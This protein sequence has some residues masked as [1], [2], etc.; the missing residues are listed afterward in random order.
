VDQRSS[1][2]FG[3]FILNRER[4]RLEDR[5]GA[6][7]FLR[8][9]SYR[10]LEVL[11]ERHGQLVSKD[12]LVCE[13]WPDLF[14]S[15]DS[16]A[17]C[18][19]DIRRALG[20]EG[21]NLLRTVPKRGYMLGA[22]AAP[23]EALAPRRAKLPP[24][25]AGLT[26]ALAVSAIWWGMAR[27]PLQAVPDTT[28][29]SVRQANALLET[30]DWRRR[31]D[32][33]RAR[34]LLESAAAEDP[35]NADTLASLGLTYWLGVQHIA[36]GGGRREMRRALELVE[37]AVA[38]GG[39]ARSHRLLAEMRL[40]SPFADM[41]SPVDALAS[42]RA[43]VAIDDDDA[44]NLA[45]LAQA[46]A[47]TGRAKEAVG[48][49]EHALRLE[50]S[51]PDWRLQ[52][53]GLTYLLAGDP[54]RAAEKLGPIYGAGTFGNTRWWP[55]WLFAASLAQA[56]RIEEAARVVAAVRQQ[57]PERSVAAVAQSFAGFADEQGLRLLLDGLR[58]A[59]M[60]G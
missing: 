58:L 33:E 39:S 31:E 21:S 13:A 2:R 52:V 9:K 56:G 41:R 6:E 55:G 59:G 16:L 45:V 48:V 7:R 4:G 10:V 17:H 3:G 46:L 32:N 28:L 60:P 5:T 47:L 27:E 19:S 57:R 34:A 26:L 44:D 20:P 36:W 38:L 29:S 43:A 24:W 30:R 14:V 35:E 11:C 1:I 37:H 12:D 54:A 50:P 23:A 18:V 15:D 51:S 40:L 53:A 8:P 49:I 22:P 25:A 42:A